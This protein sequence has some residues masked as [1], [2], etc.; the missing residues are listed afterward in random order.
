MKKLIT[1]IIVMISTFGIASAQVG[2]NDTNDEYD[3]EMY[4]RGKMPFNSDN[5][6]VF[7]KVVEVN[8]MTSD[9]IYKVMS[10]TLISCFDVD[11]ISLL[12]R[13]KD[14]AVVTLTAWMY[15]ASHG[16][17]VSAFSGVGFKCYFSVKVQCKDGRY[18][19]EVYNLKGHRDEYRRNNSIY[20]EENVAAEA[21]NDKVCIKRNGP[22]FFSVNYSY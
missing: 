8:N 18:K 12:D 14:K 6:V 13:D 4:G 20:Q 1:L 2:L 5:Q 9:D 17:F 10:N 7:S 21:L 19:I 11:K 16:E 15:T 22:A 3:A